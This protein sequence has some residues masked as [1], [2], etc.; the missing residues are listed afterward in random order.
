MAEKLIRLQQL[1]RFKTKADAKYQDKL[2][3]GSNITI[4][5]NTIS[6]T[7]TPSFVTAK[8]S[9]SSSIDSG[10]LTNV[11]TVTLQPGTYIVQYTCQFGLSN[12][13]TYRQIGFS[14]NTTSIDGLGTSGWDNR[15][16]ITG[17]ITQTWVTT[18]VVVSAT[19]YPNGRKFYLLARQDSGS[20][21]TVYPRCYYLKFG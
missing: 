20:S 13:G 14:T 18:P 5:G 10:T 2:T 8:G 17:I 21:L 1:Q 4:S 19:D 7:G 16:P 12:G 11:G 9:G 3:A 6:A 15:K